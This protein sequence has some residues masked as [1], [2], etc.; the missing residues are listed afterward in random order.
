M[1]F[2]YSKVSDCQWL[3]VSQRGQWFLFLMRQLINRIN[4]RNKYSHYWCRFLSLTKNLSYVRINTS[5]CSEWKSV[6][7]TIVDTS[8]SLT[9]VTV[10]VCLFDWYSLLVIELNNKTVY[11][12]THPSALPSLWAFSWNWIISFFD[13][14][15]ETHCAWQNL[16]SCKKNFLSQ[17]LG[18]WSKNSFFKLKD[19]VINFYSICSVMRIDFIYKFILFTFYKLHMWQ[20]SLSWDMVQNTLSQSDC[21]IFKSAISP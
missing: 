21:R 6:V 5:A 8:Y 4:D 12:I 9:D 14:V 1:F 3:S 20:N 11:G 19:L 17:K 10:T 2:Y 7:I 18:K 16:I 13:L 15:L